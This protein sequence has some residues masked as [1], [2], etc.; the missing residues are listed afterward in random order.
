MTITLLC[1]GQGAQNVGMGKAWADASPAAMGV[2]READEVL[3]DSLGA[4]LSKLCFEGPAERLNRT[5]VSQPAIYVC[6]VACW[7][8]L[9]SATPT[10]QPIAAAGLS[11]GEYT[12]LHLAG[13]FD[14]ATGLRLVALRGRLMQ[15]AAEASKGGMVA[16]IGADEPTA[17]AICA[18]AAGP[19]VLVC[20]NFN[21]P[22]QIVISGHASA[23]ERAVAAAESR[24]VRSS[25]LAVAGAFHSPLMAPAADGMRK[26]L[27]EISLQQPTVEVWS[28]VM[29]LPHTPGDRELLCK[30]LVEQLTS[31][32]RWAESCAAMLARRSCGYHELAPGAVLKGL[33]RRIDRKVEVLNHDQP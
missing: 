21:A 18:E 26:A 13:V 11:L 29:A 33:M 32:V 12:A 27:S 20:A 10:L 9:R 5:D 6:S 28:N 1:P 25:M 2:F 7:Q 23:C 24:G 15:Q 17:Q 22:G 30:R 31:P 14:F 3:G 16:L 8:G 4:S 19:D